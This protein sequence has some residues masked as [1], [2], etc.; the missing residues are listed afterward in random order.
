MKSGCSGDSLWSGVLD[1]KLG[2]LIKNDRLLTDSAP[3]G[4]D[5]PSPAVKHEHSYSLGTASGMTSD[6]D[7]IPDSPLSL[8]DGKGS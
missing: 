7:S 8:N 3:I 1:N 6:G 2:N 5:G 4:Q